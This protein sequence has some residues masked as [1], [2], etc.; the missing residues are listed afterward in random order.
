MGFAYGGVCCRVSPPPVHL[1]IEIRFFFAYNIWGEVLH[2]SGQ[3]NSTLAQF[4]YANTL[5]PQASSR[6]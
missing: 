3:K 2:V 6:V 4:S 1:A 5:R